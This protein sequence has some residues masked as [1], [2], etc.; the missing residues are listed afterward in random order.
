MYTVIKLR[1]YL[2]SMNEM[3][4]YSFSISAVINQRKCQGVHTTPDEFELCGDTSISYSPWVQDSSIS[5]CDKA[6]MKIF[7]DSHPRPPRF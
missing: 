3:R 5:V 7:Q 1:S 4:I 6:I 2:N